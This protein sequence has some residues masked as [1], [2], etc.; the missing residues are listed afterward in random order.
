MRVY[1]F[2]H[3]GFAVRLSDLQY[4]HRKS[5]YYSDKT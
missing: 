1:Q 3:V 5:E 4:S 2:R